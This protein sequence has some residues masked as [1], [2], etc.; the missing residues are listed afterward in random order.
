MWKVLLAHT[1]EDLT[2]LKEKDSYGRSPVA[3]AILYGHVNLLECLSLT[4]L[5]QLPEEEK[6]HINSKQA[7]Q[8]KENSSDSKTAPSLHA[9]TTAVL[10]HPYCR[11]HY[12]CPPSSTEEL[13]APP[14]NFRRLSVVI[15]EQH[16][17]LRSSDLEPNLMFIEECRKAVL[18]DVLRVHEWTYVRRLQALCQGRQTLY[19]H[20]VCFFLL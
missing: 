10:T 9:P 6:R 14:E 18:S 4:V 19:R 20:V 11:M 7:S 3:T 12:T 1:G 8:S 5:N 16:G 13:S 15:D 17:A 2:P